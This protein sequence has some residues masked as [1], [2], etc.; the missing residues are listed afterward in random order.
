MLWGSVRNA[1]AAHWLVNSP[2]GSYSDG[3]STG[4]A[5]HSRS[6]WITSSGV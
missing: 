5:S 1:A 2:R 4:S 3:S 6:F